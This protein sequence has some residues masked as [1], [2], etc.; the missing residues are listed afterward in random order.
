[1]SA[2]QP[3]TRAPSSELDLL[4]L[5][6]H[7]RALAAADLPREDW[8]MQ[9]MQLLVRL[10][11]PA[12][13][14]YALVVQGQ[15]GKGPRIVSRQALSWHPQIETLMVEQVRAACAANKAV[16]RRLHDIQPGLALIAAPTREAEPEGIALLLVEGG[17]SLET[18][19]TLLQLFA[20]YVAF[21]QRRSAPQPSPPTPPDP[22]PWPVLLTILRAEDFTQA[23]QNLLDALEHGFHCQ[24][25]VLCSRKGRL[26]R[27]QALSGLSEIRR[28][29]DF[30]H[31]VESYCN[32]PAALE[33]IIDSAQTV[34]PPL[35]T[36]LPRLLTASG[37]GRLVSFPLGLNPQAHE[38]ASPPP[39]AVLILL[40]KETAPLDPIAPLAP[41]APALGQALRVQSRAHPGWLRRGWR[42]LST[43]RVKQGLAIMFPLVLMGLMALPV[44]HRLTAECLLEPLERRFVAV[45]FDGQLRET[46]REPGDMVT[47][48]EVLAR[49][50]DREIEWRLSGLRAEYSR[51]RK[52]KDIRSAARETSAAQIAALEMEG[53]AAQIALLEYQM[54]NLEIKSPVEGMLLTGDWK[55][56]VGGPVSQ[57]QGLFEIAPLDRMRVEMA[58]AADDVAYAAPGQAV[59]L[60]LSAFP[61]ESWEKAVERIRP[62]AESRDSDHVFVLESE[63]ENPA[64][65]LRPGMRGRAKI[66]AGIR[67]LGWVLFHKVWERLIL[68]LG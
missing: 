49:L 13:A 46:L 22:T 26:Y 51:A 6:H 42:W 39:E 8:L 5:H 52:Q 1:M 56:A 19:V 61:G 53:L 18:F 3:P 48:G 45:P 24:R 4:A 23:G 37:A 63:L 57:G 28:Q 55:R 68:W 47:T 65:K 35:A 17:L 64:R 33:A 38:D 31:I 36:D 10:T 12:A 9:L 16:L 20:G 44:P 11:N 59:S 15:L 58:L 7:L 32:H 41:L 14:L 29:A 30:T 2:T 67:P 27:L 43:S 40:W 60:S 25:V 34:P 54:A 62:R 66:T 21:H 50:D